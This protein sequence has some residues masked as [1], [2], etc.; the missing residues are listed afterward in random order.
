MRLMGKTNRACQTISSLAKSWFE[1]EETV[2]KRRDG[3]KVK[4]W[5]VSEE[6]VGK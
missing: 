4:R 2:G 6:T 5:L 3:W 1:S